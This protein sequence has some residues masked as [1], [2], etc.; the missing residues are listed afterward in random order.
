MP[1]PFAKPRAGEPVRFSADAFGAM[2]DVARAYRRGELSGANGSA[3]IP[4]GSGRIVVKVKNGTGATIARYSPVGIGAST[5]LAN[6]PGWHDD[7]RL[8][9]AEAFV[10]GHEHR[11]GIAIEPIAN[12]SIGRV[13]VAGV[14]ICRVSWTGTWA[15][16]IDGLATP[17]AP[18]AGQTSIRPHPLGR[19]SI[20]YAA[21]STGSD[22][23]AVVM[24]GGPRPIRP[25]W[26]RLNTATPIGGASHR[27]TY[28]GSRCRRTSTGWALLDPTVTV[29]GIY[30]AREAFN[31]A[32]GIQGNGIDVTTVSDAGTFPDGFALQPA[33][34]G[35]P[36]VQ[37]WPEPLDD[38]AAAWSIDVPNAIDG[39]CE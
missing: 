31:T 8:H 6:D 11:W 27:W 2:L 1:D 29:A 5:F 20:L 12:G 4:G 7:P 35:S 3:S 25:Y 39:A 18:A 17:F 30:N 14:A 34:R 9:A 26:V 22:I 10:V 36:V 24:L 15:A 38:G 32:S 28:S 16:I 19:A 33:S 13:V 37:A 21:S 23:D